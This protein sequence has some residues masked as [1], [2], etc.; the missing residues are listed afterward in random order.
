MAWHDRNVVEQGLEHTPLSKPG[1]DQPLSGTAAGE[2]Q[3]SLVSSLECHRDNCRV[4]KEKNKI[5]HHFRKDFKGGKGLDVFKSLLYH[6][7]F[8]NFHNV[9]TYFAIKYNMPVNCRPL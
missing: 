1:Y 6:C 9:V 5:K 3:V 2:S 7:F 8:F 4:N